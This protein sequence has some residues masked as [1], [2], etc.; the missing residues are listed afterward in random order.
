MVHFESS[1]SKRER[2]RRREC[3]PRVL[4]QTQDN[5]CLFMHLFLM[6]GNIDIRMKIKPSVSDMF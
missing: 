4:I 2:N 1:S 5:T 3:L 6:A